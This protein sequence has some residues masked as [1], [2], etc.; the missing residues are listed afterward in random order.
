VTR[1][2][3]AQVSLIASPVIVSPSSGAVV[4][5]AIPRSAAWNAKTS[6][7]R[8]ST[9]RRSTGWRSRAIVIARPLR[10]VLKPLD[11]AL[12]GGHEL[13]AAALEGC[14]DPLKELDGQPLG[15]ERRPQL[16]G[17][18]GHQLFATRLVVA[19]MGHI[20]QHEDVAGAHTTPVPERRRPQHVAVIAPSVEEADFDGLLTLRV[21]Q[22]VADRAAEPD[23][24]G[25]V[26]AE[27]LEA[28]AERLSPLAAKDRTR[29]IVHVDNDALAVKDDETVL[30]AL[31]DRLDD[32]D[33]TPLD[34]ERRLTGERLEQ[35]PLLARESQAEPLDVHRE[36][37]DGPA[38]RAEW[39]V[40]PSPPQAGSPCHSPLVDHVARPTSLSPSP[41]R[42]AP[43][44]LG[45][46][47][48][49]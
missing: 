34:R 44:P 49:P 2:E 40:K 28:V 11:I 45:T 27:R 33:P 37:T 35:L 23:V 5:K 6:P 19:Q 36:D 21:R 7:T 8:A 38:H 29:H 26:R 46:R 47:C 1:F 32:V 15:G 42:S 10:H 43:C 39:H 20:L 17:Q 4:S 22:E 14:E 18:R 30:D 48:A 25:V 41:A 3:S 9:A 24:V 16:V 31:D 13:A 12:D